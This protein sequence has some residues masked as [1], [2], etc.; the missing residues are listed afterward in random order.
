M[1]KILM[2]HAIKTMLAKYEC[3]T[4]QDYINALKEIFQE[5][6]LLALWRAK[7][8]EKAAFYGGSALRILYGL[9]RFSEDLD[10]TLLK[11]DKHFSLSSYNRAISEELKS[12]GFEVTVETKNK[13]I[14]SAIESAFIKAES[15]KQLIVIETPKDIVTPLHSMHTIK[16]KMEVDT[17]PPGKFNTDVKNILQPLPFSIKTLTQPDLFAGKIHA[18]LCRPWQTRVKGRDWYDFVWYIGRAIPVNLVHLRERLIQTKAWNKNTKLTDKD[19][20]ELLTKKIKETDF[21]NAKKDVIFF[22]NDKYAVNLWSTA[23]FLEITQKIL[24]LS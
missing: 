15:K 6:A 19:L 8:Y 23:F 22:L 3:H 14:E 16:I 7:F 17:A 9:D 11:E 1:E 21:E 24:T 13:N 4:E 20:T 10:F 12:F 5:I 18:L 2:H